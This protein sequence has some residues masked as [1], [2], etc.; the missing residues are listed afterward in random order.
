[1]AAE[2]P[3]MADAVC[4]LLSAHVTSCARMQLVALWH[5]LH[6]GQELPGFAV[7]EGHNL[8]RRQRKTK[9]SLMDNE[10]EMSAF[11]TRRRGMQE[12]DAFRVV[13]LN[14]CMRTFLCPQIAGR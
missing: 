14:A 13:S 6:P 5:Y 11:F 9:A 4:L 10:C 3:H 2:F 12:V 1:M 7:R 8:C